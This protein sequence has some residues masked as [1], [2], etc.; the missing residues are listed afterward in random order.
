MRRIARSLWQSATRLTLKECLCTEIVA[1]LA[2]VPHISIWNARALAAFH[3]GTL[4]PK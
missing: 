4:L 1:E 3:Q 2:T